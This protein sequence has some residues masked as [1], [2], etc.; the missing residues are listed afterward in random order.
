MK[1]WSNLHNAMTKKRRRIAPSSFLCFMDLVDLLKVN[2]HLIDM[3]CLPM[4]IHL[5]DCSRDLGYLL[6]LLFVVYH[7]DLLPLLQIQERIVDLLFHIVRQ[8]SAGL[9]VLFLGCNGFFQALEGILSGIMS[10]HENP[11]IVTVTQRII[12]W[13]FMITIF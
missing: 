7:G 3:Q 9:R 12:L 6:L 11:Q 5:H 8:L 4:C 10:Y 13:I 1:I 2:A